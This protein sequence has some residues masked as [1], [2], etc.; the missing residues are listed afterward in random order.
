MSSNHNNDITITIPPHIGN[1]F[2]HSSGK[3][4]Y[5]KNTFD[6]R[7]MNLEAFYELNFQIYKNL[8]KEEKYDDEVFLEVKRNLYYLEESGTF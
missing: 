2:N 7:E 6:D 4:D 3:R 1:I 8:L 5:L